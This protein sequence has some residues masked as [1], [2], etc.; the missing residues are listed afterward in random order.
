MKCMVKG[1]RCLMLSASATAFTGITALG[2]IIVTGEN[3][4]FASSSQPTAAYY[5]PQI[6]INDLI[7]TSQPSLLN[8]SRDKTPFFESTTLNDGIGC[9]PT[10]GT[11]GTYLPATFDGGR[12]PATYTF[13]LAGTSSLYVQGYNITEIR[14]YAGWNA[15]GSALGNQKY[16]LLVSTIDTAEFISLGTFTYAPFNSSD[17]NAASATKMVLTASGGGAITTRVDAI[18]FVIMDHGYKNGNTS[19][20]GSVFYEIDVIGHANNPYVVPLSYV[21][22][23]SGQG[24]HPTNSPVHLWPDTGGIELINGILPATA[25]YRDPQWVGFLDDPPDDGTEQPQVTFSFDQ[26]YRFEQTEI[27]YF[28]SNS[29][30]GGSITAP[31]SVWV[32]FSLDGTLWSTPVEKSGFDSSSGDEIRTTTVS[33][34]TM[35]GRYVRM[36]FRNTSQWTFLGEVAFKGTAV[37]PPTGTVILVL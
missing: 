13:N 21:Y 29:Q 30:A 22:D 28:H 17:P 27:T 6:L 19:I 36:D 10:G 4:F 37:G 23:G 3:V 32:S 31:E 8:W 5:T 2:E 24:S 9:P 26:L 35:K 33:L 11:K 12:L 14:S 7:D 34:D 18:R 16:E 15:N 20:D 1:Y 25:D